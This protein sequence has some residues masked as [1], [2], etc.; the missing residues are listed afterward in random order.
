MRCGPSG[1]AC[2]CVGPPR[3]LKSY[4][5]T[6]ARL[7]SAQDCRSLP[8]TRSSTAFLW[9]TASSQASHCSV[10]LLHNL[11]EDLCIPMDFHGLQ[12]HNCFTI[13]LTTSCRGISYSS[14]STD[15][16]VRSVVPLTY[17]L[18]WP[19]LRMSNSIVCLWVFSLLKYN[20]QNC[21][22]C[23]NCCCNHF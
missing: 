23:C 11:K 18:L 9:F 12:R 1:T 8:G 4:Q 5:E 19:Q 6:C 3:D 2:S 15:L 17:S 7:L 13:V 21:C 14:F 22:C 16:G 20:I 10:S